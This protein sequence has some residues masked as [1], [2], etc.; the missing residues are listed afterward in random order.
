MRDGKITDAAGQRSLTYADLA[1][2]ED[3]AKHFEQ[4][5][6]ADVELTGG[7]GLEGAGYAG[8]S[9]PTGATL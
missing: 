1:S 9:G 4:A 7:Q 5:I 3:A 2:N 8:A 6:P